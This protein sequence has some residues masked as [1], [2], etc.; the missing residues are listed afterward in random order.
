MNAHAPSTP[1]GS[2][3]RSRQI[4]GEVRERVLRAASTLGALGGGATSAPKLLGTLCSQT[5]TARDISQ[6]LGREPAL[7]ARVL[8]IANSPFYG[9]SRTVSSVEK[10]I[11]LLGLDSIRG[12]VAAACLD[13]FAAQPAS[14]VGINT[15][16]VVAHCLATAAAADALSAHL[17]R[18][19]TN[20]AFLAGLLHN[21]GVFVQ[22]R[23]DGDRMTRVADACARNP[24]MSIREIE[25]GAGIVTHEECFAIL[26]DAWQL[27]A[28]IAL[29]GAHHH[30]P[31]EAPLEHRTVVAVAGLAAR[32]AVSA[33]FRHAV[34]PRHASPPSEFLQLLEV[35]TDMLDETCKLIPEMVRALGG[36]LPAGY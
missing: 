30:K 20:D 28:P 6:L 23:L 34:D 18:G 36:A 33:G 15:L 17:P 14:S 9:R 19:S 29:A 8:R 26:A 25:H 3:P 35:E 21:L 27:P 32:L 1:A 16:D 4:P 5:T 31:S 12:I 13:R 2:T 11:V 22:L 10:A 24:S 7:T